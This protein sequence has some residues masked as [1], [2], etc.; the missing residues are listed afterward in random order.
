MMGAVPLFHALYF[1]Y[2]RVGVV[3]IKY[4][5]KKTR[6]NDNTSINLQFA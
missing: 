6:A 3:T 1:E 4:V 2:T 5:N